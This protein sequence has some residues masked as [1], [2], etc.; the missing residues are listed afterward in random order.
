M[1]QRESPDRAALVLH[2]DASC[3]QTADSDRKP[4][5]EMNGGWLRGKIAAECRPTMVCHRLEIERSVERTQ[6]L[7]L[8][9]AGVARHDDEWSFRG[10]AREHAEAMVAKRFEAAGD[11]R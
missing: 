10:E 1:R 11:A 8:A 5:L 6:Q 9:A 3:G 7:R 2:G 4:I